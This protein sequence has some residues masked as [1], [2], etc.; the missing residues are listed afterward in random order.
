MIFGSGEFVVQIMNVNSEQNGTER[1]EPD[2]QPRLLALLVHLHLP[3]FQ[4]LEPVDIGTRRLIGIINGHFRLAFTS[5]CINGLA[6]LSRIVTIAIAIAITIATTIIPIPII[7]EGSIGAREALVGHQRSTGIRQFVLELRVKAGSITGRK[8]RAGIVG[9]EAQVDGLAVIGAVGSNVKVIKCG[10][11]RVV[12]GVKVGTCVFLIDVK[13]TN[14][15]KIQ[16]AV[17][18]EKKQ[19][20]NKYRTETYQSWNLCFLDRCEK[21]KL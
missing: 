12:D 9:E 11:L 10:T 5:I 8:L 13:K 16:N 6:V 14:C 19:I 21:N 20:V 3:I 4:M 1:Q 18:C 15:K 17:R 7:L 2:A